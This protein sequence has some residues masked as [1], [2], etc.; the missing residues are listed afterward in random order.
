M[1]SRDREP[2][3]GEARM[4]G[5]AEQTARAFLEVFKIDEQPFRHLAV[6]SI[7]PPDVSSLVFDNKDGVRFS[8]NRT[9][10]YRVIESQMLGDERNQLHRV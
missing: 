5:H 10:P 4:N 6:R 3:H 8:R 1:D 7:E 2:T 9:E